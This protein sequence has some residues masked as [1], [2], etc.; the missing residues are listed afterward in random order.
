MEIYTD[1]EEVFHDERSFGRNKE[2]VRISN[3]PSTTTPPQIR[4]LPRDNAM[5]RMGYIAARRPTGTG[6]RKPT[7]GGF[8]RRTN[9]WEKTKKEWESAISHTRQRL[10]RSGTYQETHQPANCGDLQRNIKALL[11]LLIPFPKW[12]R[13]VLEVGGCG[14]GWGLG[15][16]RWWWC[17]VGTSWRLACVQLRGNTSYWFIDRWSTETVHY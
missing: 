17:C 8:P 14:V 1:I 3:Q 7:S 15:V 16:R 4:H 12:K 9:F 10:H 2:R 6:G 5:V 11:L 13:N